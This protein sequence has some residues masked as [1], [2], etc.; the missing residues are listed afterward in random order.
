MP[1]A[2]YHRVTITT[3]YRTT[4]RRAY[5][6]SN[7][8]PENRTAFHFT[9]YHHATLPFV[10]GTS[11]L[12]ASPTLNPTLPLCDL[13]A[14]VLPGIDTPF[15]FCL[16]LCHYSFFSF[17]FL[18]HGG[19]CPRICITSCAPCVSSPFSSRR[20]RYALSLSFRVCVRS[21]APRPRRAN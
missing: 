16:S 19:L 3:G 21:C 13:T 6:S 7:E 17:P 5:V 1:V 15:F 14:C 10:Q 11:L 9:S 4:R 20:W 2:G 8:I 12:A 18:P